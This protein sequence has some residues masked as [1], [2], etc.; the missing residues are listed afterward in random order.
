MT[1]QR[2]SDQA[3][4]A[5]EAGEPPLTAPTWGLGEVAWGFV[6]A[7][8][9]GLIVG[10]VVV[11]AAGQQSGAID[12][13]ALPLWALLLR[14]PPLWIGF[15]GL[16]VWAAC[17]CG[18][19]VRRD[20]RLAIRAGEVAPAALVGVVAQ[21]VL[22]P[23]VSWPL[24]KLTGSTAGD[25]SESATT[26]VDKAATPGAV[27]LL[28]VVVVIGAPIAEELFFRGLLLGAIEKRWSMTAGVIGSSAVFGATHFQ[29]LL[30]PG[31]ATAGLV[32]ALVRA[33][34]GRLGPAIVTHMAFNATAVV[35][36]LRN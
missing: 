10:S 2:S 29:P 35:A 24:L 18:N 4:S 19:G 6:V 1:T 9:S 34:T 30:F 13:S 20:F 27:V 16:P 31:L 22:V 36:L 26:L 12:E 3:S 23:L 15:I 7:Q 5:V 25:L 14:S 28:F 33:R 32:F 8:V 17:R 21:L 11:A